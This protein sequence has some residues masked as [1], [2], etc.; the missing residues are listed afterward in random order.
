MTL[1]MT[2]GSGLEGPSSATTTCDRGTAKA[3]G[4]AVPSR[5]LSFFE[6]YGVV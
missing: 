6:R 4:H 5:P 3:P 1:V 2:S